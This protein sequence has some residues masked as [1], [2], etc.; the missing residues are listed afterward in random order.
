MTI[1]LFRTKKDAED[2]CKHIKRVIHSAK[3]KPIRIRFNW[4]DRG[5]FGVRAFDFEEKDGNIYYIVADSKSEVLKWK[6]NSKVL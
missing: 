5:R 1:Q 6:L 4:K 3:L 2:E